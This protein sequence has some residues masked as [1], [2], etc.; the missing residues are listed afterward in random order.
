[1]K[2][3]RAFAHLVL[4]FALVCG[5]TISSMRDAAADNAPAPIITSVFADSNLTTLTV[6][7]AN[8]GTSGDLYLAGVKLTLVPPYTSSQLTAVLPAGVKPGGYLLSL[9]VTKVSQPEEFWVTLGSG[10]AVGPQGPA[11]PAGAQGPA[12]PA[13]PAGPTGPKGDTGAT[14]T[15]GA[16]G[17]TGATGPK[18]DAGATGATG[19]QGLQGP[20]GDTGPTGAIGPQG[21]KG[22]TGAT[23]AQGPIGPQGPQG[24]AG[25]ASNVG[26]IK[27]DVMIC[28]Q[29]A[30]HTLVYIPGQSFVAYAGAVGDFLLSNLPFGNYDVVLEATGQTKTISGVSVQNTQ[31][32]DTGTT[33]LN[34]LSGDPKN[35]GA[36][37]NVCPAAPNTTAGCQNSQCTVG[38]CNLGFADCNGIAADGCEINVFSDPSNCGNCGVVCA[39]GGT[40]S[41]GTCACSGAA[42]DVCSGTCVNKLTDPS[43][44]GLCGHSCNGGTCNGGICSAPPACTTAADCHGAATDQCQINVCMAGACMIGSAPQGTTCDMGAGQCSVGGQCVH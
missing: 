5:I 2:T 16:T 15:T 12:G 20:K 23:G 10:G 19:A 4:C 24:P 29:S 44:C 9:I 34:D 28:A 25:G 33:T 37:N 13:G 17:A 11:G 43:N 21:P 1:M 31:T 38:T 26:S 40:C 42:P 22:D 18:G 35:C 14:G 3:L 39:I 7:G 36:C 8:F 32:V 41:K 30:A 6:N 27:G